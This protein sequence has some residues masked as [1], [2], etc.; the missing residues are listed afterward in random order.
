MD[1]ESS[2]YDPVQMPEQEQL[3]NT[4][5]ECLSKHYQTTAV[6]SQKD[7]S[8]RTLEHLHYQ[9]ESLKRHF[10]CREIAE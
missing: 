7:P 4:L 1:L 8:T 9:I 10:G 6:D 3:K 5:F 2:Q